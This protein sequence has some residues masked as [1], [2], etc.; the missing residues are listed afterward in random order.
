MNKTL[1]T[2]MHLQNES[3]V[4]LTSNQKCRQHP[5]MTPFLGTAYS[6]VTILG[7][8]GNI[9]L[10]Y[11]IC[12]QK[13]RGNV[14]HILIANL[15]F[16]DVLVCAFCLPFT[17]VYTVMDYWVFGL[18]LCKITNFLQCASVTV[19]VLIL[20]L[21]AFERYQ[22]ILHPTGWKPSVL[23]AYAAVLLVW[24]IA[25]L[26]AFPLASSMVLTDTQNKNISK[27]IGFLADKSVC[28]ESWSSNQQLVAYT[29]SL[30]LLQYIVPLCFILGCYLRISVHLKHRGAMFGRSD[31]HMRRVNLMFVTMVGA[32]AVCWLPFHI[33]NIIV[34]WQHQLIPVCYHNLIF[35]LCHLLAMISTCVNPVIYGLLNSNVKREVKALVQNCTGR[36]PDTRA[37][38]EELEKYPLSVKQNVTLPGSPSIYLEEGTFLGHTVS[39]EEH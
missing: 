11:V 34:D 28:V 36:K 31:N 20:V 12:R 3:F 9:S 27:V 2:V 7:L 8:L 10:I 35:S 30:Q 16:S 17:A 19:S 14:T 4:F 22:L 21:I 38:V 24:I 13:E 25:S 32:F 18:G 1:T 39:T 26:L 15:A 5:D 6:L 29:I 37:A 23:Q 33:F